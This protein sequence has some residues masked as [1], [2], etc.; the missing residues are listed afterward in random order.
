MDNSN[1]FPNNKQPDQPPLTQPAPEVQPTYAPP[2][3]SPMPVEPTISPPPTDTTTP[4]PPVTPIIPITPPADTS[5]P[6]EAQP[7]KKRLWIFVIIATVLLLALL[8]VVYWFVNRSI[9]P[10]SNDPDKSQSQSLIGSKYDKYVESG[11]AE[12]SS[13]KKTLTIE[14]LNDLTKGFDLTEK[15]YDD[16]VNA[17]IALALARLALDDSANSGE[18]QN[19]LYLLA[20][21]YLKT[22]PQ[23]ITDK[24]F[25]SAEKNA[26]TLSLYDNHADQDLTEQIND[27][28][29]SSDILSDLKKY[30]KLDALKEASLV[31]LDFTS[32]GS[33]QKEFVKLR[34]IYGFSEQ[35]QIWY[36][37]LE[38]KT[39]IY[40]TSDG[41]QL[42]LN[43]DDSITQLLKH[44]LVYSQV[45]Y[46]RG[47]LGSVFSA[48]MAYAFSELYSYADARF[49]LGYSEVL[50]GV[51][52]LDQM[53]SK[54]T[55]ILA[56]YL[57]LYK[58]YGLAAA[59]KAV[60]AWI[61][62][63][64]KYHPSEAI[65]RTDKFLGSADSFIQEAASIG[66]CNKSAMHQRIDEYVGKLG[67]IE[68]SEG[69]TVEDYLT[70]MNH[71]MPTFSKVVIEYL[72]S[73]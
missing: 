50:S 58:S 56:F 24:T 64:L 18:Y 69:I 8:G 34:P 3:P 45:S 20:K 1:L 59:N 37:V 60:A 40:L 11:I 61:E 47:E 38:G 5:Q 19:E 25:V 54:P 14:K 46:A 72:D 10:A 27:Y 67:Q 6:P 71:N 52:L 7:K 39:Q 28:L 13:D 31:A 29:D 35:P 16:D 66:N 43:D 65:K 44:F 62:P 73:K 68:S 51:D 70:N 23:G 15:F 42:L 9:E 36:E 55:D 48:E 26:E 57:F 2:A 21:P 17:L 30:L 33:S 4:T 49:M 41:A 22:L 63:T 32:S 53:S 12:F